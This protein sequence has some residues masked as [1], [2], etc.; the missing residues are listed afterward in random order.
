MVSGLT[1]SA[2]LNLSKEEI[3]SAGDGLGLSSL[4]CSLYA[5]EILGSNSNARMCSGVHMA[6]LVYGGQR[7]TP[8]SQF[9]VSTLD[10]GI[11]ET[12]AVRLMQQAL[13][14]F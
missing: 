3:A 11:K 13:L 5:P 2:F 6:W 10:L 7:I 4:R 12:Q 8:R 9:F 1:G 14:P